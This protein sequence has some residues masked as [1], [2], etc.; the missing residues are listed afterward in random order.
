MSISLTAGPKNCITLSVP[1]VDANYAKLRLVLQF[2]GD[3]D[4]IADTAKIVYLL[5]KEKINLIQTD[6]A[7]YTPGQL[8]RFRVLSLTHS[9]RPV[10]SPVNHL[11]IYYL[12]SFFFLVFAGLVVNGLVCV[13][14]QNGSD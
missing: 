14:C 10:L 5:D 6:K 3:Q 8:V 7:W 11:L 12:I 9:L 13:F 1:N 2:D 4:F